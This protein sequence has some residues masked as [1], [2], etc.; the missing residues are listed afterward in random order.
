MAALCLSLVTSQNS[1][2]LHAPAWLQDR[3]L[4]G[5]PNKASYLFLLSLSYIPY[6]T[7]EW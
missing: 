7:L 4:R 1:V 5:K 3:L 2:T 6:S